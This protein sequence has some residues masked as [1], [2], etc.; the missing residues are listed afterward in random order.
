MFTW[1]IIYHFT[2]CLCSLN[3]YQLSKLGVNLRLD[4]TVTVLLL[5]PSL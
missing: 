3:H 5:C 2:N 4:K 1:L